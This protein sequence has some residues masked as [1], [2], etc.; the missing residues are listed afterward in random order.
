M[1]EYSNANLGFAIS[2]S[3]FFLAELNRDASSVTTT[4]SLTNPDGT[5]NGSALIEVSP[6]EMNL[7]QYISDLTSSK[8]ISDQHKTT[9]AGIPAYEGVSNGLVSRYGLF[10]IA[11]EKAYRLTFYTGNDFDTVE[12]M[13]SNLSGSQ[14]EVIATFALIK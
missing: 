8:L 14:K 12:K 11:N 3:D 1:K 7:D 13:K 10:F 6:T 2:Y 4:L 5:Q 9:I